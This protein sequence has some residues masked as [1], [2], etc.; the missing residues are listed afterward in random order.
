[1]KSNVKM[2]NPEKVKLKHSIELFYLNN[3]S[4]DRKNETYHHFKNFKHNG[5]PIYTKSSLYELMKKLDLRGTLD[6]KSGS[7]RPQK[8][9][10]SDKKKLKKIVNHKTG[11]SQ[12]KIATKFKVS[13]PTI[14]RNLKKMN[15]FYRKRKRAPK[16]TPEQKERQSERLIKFVE[17]ILDGRDLVIDDES[18]F[19]LSGAGMP[20]NSGFYTNDLD[21]TPPEIKFNRVAK[22]EPDKVMIWVAFSKRGISPIY[23]APKRT[24]MDQELYRK[25]CLTKRLF[26]FIDQNYDSRQDV[27][28]WPDLASCHY[29]TKTQQFLNE[30]GIF[31]VPKDHNPPN[32]PQI[33][34]I[35]NFFGILKQRVYAGNW[36]AKNRDQ[37]IQRIR[38]CVR[39]MDMDVIIKMYE[40]LEKKIRKASV[41]GLESLL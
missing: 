24:S 14:S 12:R 32:C 19:T 37:L 31:F 3:K 41:D 8:L 20:G 36:S 23:F 33:R 13:H 21:T 16:Q 26:P 35:E 25:E 10:E 27:I 5:H 28:F 39:E 34:P 11:K 2:A 6:R 7:G 40:N 1:M 9:N 4:K 18:Y 29:A 15:V 38:K 30:N 17:N 22:F